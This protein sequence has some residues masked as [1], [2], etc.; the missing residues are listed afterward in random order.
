MEPRREL[1]L[2]CPQE[3]SALALTLPDEATL[4]RVLTT[5]RRSLAGTLRVDEQWALEETLL[6]LAARHEDPRGR[7]RTLLW[8][9]ETSLQRGA[10][11]ELE[12]LLDEAGA[13]I[14][15]LSEPTYHHSHAHYRASLEFIRGDLDAAERSIEQAAEVGRRHG[16]AEP[17]VESIRFSQLLGVRHEQG[18]LADFRD[19][20]APF[21]AATQ[22]PALL[23]AVAWIDS[24]LGDLDLVAPKVD[25][26]FDDFAAGGVRITMPV[27]A[28]A[29][30]APPVVA[31]GDPARTQLLY[32]LLLPHAHRGV[33][34][35]LQAGTDWS[36][37][38]LARA[39]GREDDAQRHFAD[40]VAFSER[41]GAPRW[42]ER[43][44]ATAGLDASPSVRG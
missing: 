21:F 9:F 28:L 44:A 13:I 39:L 32:E 37:G 31:L 17:I 11:D 33:M 23:A 1:A 2:T 12:E 5:V 41:L 40:G 8:R 10:G 4:A 7:A 30:I 27:L 14:A 35:G 6:E 42:A 36:L 16:M 25:A 20:V 43:C 34:L 29:Q 19:E 26:F 22:M 24:E 3:A 18:R 38:L 15:G